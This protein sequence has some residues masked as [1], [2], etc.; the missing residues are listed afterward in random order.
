MSDLIGIA[1]CKLGKVLPENYALNAH[2]FGAVV[3]SARGLIMESSK[4]GSLV[5]DACT[6]KGVVTLVSQRLV[7]SGLGPWL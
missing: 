4:A 1:R 7:A 5:L 2:R 6:R 3:K